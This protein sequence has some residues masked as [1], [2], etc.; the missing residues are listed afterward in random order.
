MWRRPDAGA[1]T[2]A[3][4]S[5]RATGFDP[6]CIRVHPW[7]EEFSD[8]AERPKTVGHGWTRIHTDQKPVQVRVISTPARGSLIKPFEENFIGMVKP[9][10]SCTTFFNPKVSPEIY[11]DSYRRGADSGLFLAGLAALR[12]MLFGSGP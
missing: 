4:T 2:I 8:G 10:E 9:L 11:P 6:W 12:E 5:W 1:E 3:R 7:P